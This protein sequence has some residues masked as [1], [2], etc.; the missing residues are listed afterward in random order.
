MN[1]DEQ[2]AMVRANE[3]NAMVLLCAMV[4]LWAATAILIDKTLGRLARLESRLPAAE[5]KVSAR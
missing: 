1:A 5:G 2:A 3:K 4:V